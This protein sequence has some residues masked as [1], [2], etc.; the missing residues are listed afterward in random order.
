VQRKL[1]EEIRKAKAE[2]KEKVE[3]QFEGGNMRDAWKGL[4]TLTGQ[5][6][7]QCTAISTSLDE[8][9]AY[10]DKLNEFYCRFERDDLES[11]LSAVIYDLQARAKEGRQSDDDS[12]IEESAV[13]SLFKHLNIRKACGPDNVCGRIL[14][15]CAEQLSFVFTRLFSW[16]VKDCVVPSVWKNSTICPVPKNRSP[17]ELNDYRPVALTSIA[18]KCFERII[19]RS[20]LSQTQHQLDPFQFA[21]KQNRSTD[22]ATL[23]LLHNAYSHLDKSGSFVRIL[24]IDFSSAFNTI[25]PHLL[26]SKLLSLDVNPKLILW[27]VDFLVNRSQT[28]CFQQALSSSRT[29]CVG[30]PQ[31]TVLSPV[32]FTLYTNDCCGTDSSLLIKF[33]DDTALQDLSNSHSVYSDQVLQFSH[34][35]KE[36]YLDLNV[37]KTKELVV[38]F[39]KNP[40]LIPDLYIDGTK[41]ERVQ[42]YKYLG[43]VIDNKLNFN[44]NTQAVHK[45]CQSR[46]FCL[47]KLRALKVNQDV[48]S[49]FYRCFLESALTF[50]FVCW[51]AGLSVKNKNVLDRVVNVSGRVIG[52]RQQSLSV[53]YERRVVKK[54]GVIVR[55]R[56]H[57]LAQHYELLPS[58][59]RYRVPKVST[60]RSRNSFVNKSIEFLNR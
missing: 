54:A 50:G 15:F 60:I 58:G 55:D 49:S 14:R 17:S 1:R 53:L 6:K 2:Y 28:V 38:D 51:Y 52:E 44:A 36:N 37:K 42:E 20:L 43:T 24:F 41:V 59:R 10:A 30:S 16:S 39:R 27:I 45:K 21:Y 13:L 18:M 31:G 46:L 29:T 25:Q 4:K 3:K 22:D 9:V 40:P 26:A 57:V 32:I 48:L 19:L 23:T 5:N 34:W 35:C 7:P 56:A 8:R 33:S 11:D 47:Q 12:V